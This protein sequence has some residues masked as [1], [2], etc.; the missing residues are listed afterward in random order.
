MEYQYNKTGAQIN[1]LFE[2]IARFKEEKDGLS[3]ATF[4]DY[5]NKSDLEDYEIMKIEEQL[6]LILN[7]DD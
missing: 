5:R 7:T 6:Q 2:E 4:T 3:Q 1:E